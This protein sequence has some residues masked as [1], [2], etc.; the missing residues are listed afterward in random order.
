M[1]VL[2]VK[3]ISYYE[4]CS[5]KFGNGYPK[6]FSSLECTKFYPKGKS[7]YLKNQRI[8]CKYPRSMS[9]YDIKR[10]FNSENH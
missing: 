10:N 7:F 5:K 8:V 4:W 1:Y 2:N 6:G 9:I 3:C